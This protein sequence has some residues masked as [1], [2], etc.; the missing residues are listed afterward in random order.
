[1]EGYKGSRI[2]DYVFRIGVNF[3]GLIAGMNG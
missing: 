2:Q 1:M 3:C